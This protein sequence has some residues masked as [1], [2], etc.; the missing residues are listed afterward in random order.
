MKKYAKEIVIAGVQIALFYVFP[1]R[2]WLSF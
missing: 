1:A 2:R